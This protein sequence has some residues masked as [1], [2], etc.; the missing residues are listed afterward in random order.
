MAGM[1]S[2]GPGKFNIFNPQSKYDPLA[3]KVDAFEKK[4]TNPDIKDPEPQQGAAVKTENELRN[5]YEAQ[6][7][8]KLLGS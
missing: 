7:R 4:H 5:E 2:K 3:Q 6:N 8:A 1:F